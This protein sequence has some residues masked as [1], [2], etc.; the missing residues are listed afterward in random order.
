MQYEVTFTTEDL[1]K[2]NDFSQKENQSEFAISIST[3]F[4]H[5][6]PFGLN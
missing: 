3:R 2:C 6:S 4:Y 1:N 5:T